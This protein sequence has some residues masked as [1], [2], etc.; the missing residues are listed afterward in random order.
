MSSL[1]DRLER[2]DKWWI[3]LN[4]SFAFE[5]KSNEEKIKKLISLWIEKTRS[6]NKSSFKWFIM[7]SRVLTAD[8]RFFK[9]MKTFDSLYFTSE[10]CFMILISV[11]NKKSE[12]KIKKCSHVF[13][14]NEQ[15]K[16]ERKNDESWKRE[17]EMI[18]L[19]RFNADE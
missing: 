9:S 1:I 17:K 12:Q 13:A 14:T 19:R 10:S 8:L 2:W 16:L 5:I 4:F 6:R 11:S 15:K 18:V 3:R 7:T